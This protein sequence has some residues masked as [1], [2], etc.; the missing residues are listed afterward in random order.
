VIVNDACAVSNEAAPPERCW[1]GPQ[2][3]LSGAAGPR[4]R[5]R[6]TVTP[7]KLNRM[8]GYRYFA[9]RTLTDV[10]DDLP[11]CFNVNAD[12]RNALGTTPM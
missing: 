12:S 4:Q 9:G 6:A 5:K 3:E 10:L 8:F 1:S 7:L 11:P 2:G